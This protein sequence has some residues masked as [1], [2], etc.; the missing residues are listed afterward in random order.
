MT[1]VIYHKNIHILLVDNVTFEFQHQIT[2][3]EDTRPGQHQITPDEDTGTVEKTM[4]CNGLSDEQRN[5]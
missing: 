5:T 1:D 2:P 4:L 3:D